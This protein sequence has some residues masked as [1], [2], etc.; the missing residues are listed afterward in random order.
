[1]A[2]NL[3]LEESKGEKINL[4]YVPLPGLEDRFLHT[5]AQTLDLRSLGCLWDVRSFVRYI[6]DLRGILLIQIILM[7]VLVQKYF[8]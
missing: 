1:M 5:R 2:P 3:P 4:L 7:L 6:Q 8:D